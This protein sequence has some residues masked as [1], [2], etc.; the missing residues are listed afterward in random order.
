M[1]TITSTLLFLFALA[2]AAA[3]SWTTL[4]A[5]TLSWRF[6]DMFFVNEQKGWCVDGGGQI[7]RTTNGG[8]SWQQVYY[9]NEVYFRSVEFKD[10]NTGFAGALGGSSSDARLFRT[11][12][13]GDN[14]TEITANF[15][16]TVIGICGIAMADANTVFITGVFYG[17]A[18]IMRSTDL[19]ET[20][21][22]FGMGSLANGLVDIHFTDA[23][24]GIAV[25][26]SPQGTGMKAVI[27]GTDNGGDTW[28]VRAS[29]DHINQ[30]AW[31]VQFLTDDIVYASIEEFE[32]SPQYFKSTDGGQTW[33]LKDVVTAN[34]SGTMQGIGFLT[35]NIGWV[36]GWSNLLYQTLDGGDTWEYTPTV[37]GS[38]N[39]FFKIGPSK[40]LTSGSNVYLYSDPVLTGVGDVRPPDFVG[41]SIAIQGSN[42]IHGP[43]VIELGL[44][45]TTF[46]ELS[47]YDRTG[48]R[49]QLID[50][51]KREKGQHRITW[52]PDLAAGMYALV[53]YTYHGYESIQV[54]VK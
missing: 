38:F 49:V 35:E 47:V 11:M 7:I 4:N 14:W 19:G 12:D 20:W 34:S 54:V 9:D 1:R 31:K 46:A 36:G 16:Q 32:P 13:G 42:P 17:S 28:E 51:R 45:N 52:S 2:P 24:H 41:H 26:Q 40:M 33:E 53:L 15:P 37:G 6:E 43:A 21:Q 8:L 5:T 25:G 39:R 3:Q 50:A 10:E 18:Y 48:K 44:V 23:M 27:L 22:Y 30:R 29:G